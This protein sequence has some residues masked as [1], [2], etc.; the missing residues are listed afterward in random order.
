MK[1]N[2]EDTEE[3]MTFLEHLEEFRWTLGRSC[4]AFITGVVFVLWFMKDVSVFLQMPL[5]SAY[6]SAE[7]LEQNL[8]TYRPMG[9]IGLHTGGCSR[10]SQFGNAFYPIFLSLFH[11]SWIN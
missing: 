6:G 9:V 8:I 1:D 10:W 2:Q 4:F 11:C 5:L 3:G 7:L